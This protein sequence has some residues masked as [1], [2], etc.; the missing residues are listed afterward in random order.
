MSDN[1]ARNGAIALFIVALLAWLGAYVIPRDTF[2]RE[3]HACTRD[4]SRAEIARCSVVVRTRL[5]AKE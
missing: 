4:E 3:V 5:E 2:V 1:D